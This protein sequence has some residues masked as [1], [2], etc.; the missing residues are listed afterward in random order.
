MGLAHR[1]PVGSE[2]VRSRNAQTDANNAG[3]R[4]KQKVT[5]KGCGG[6]PFRPTTN[7]GCF[8]RGRVGGTRGKRWS[9]AGPQALALPC[10]I[11]PHLLL[12]AL[13]EPSIH[14]GRL[15]SPGGQSVEAQNRPQ[16]LLSLCF[17]SRPTRTHTNKSLRGLRPHSLTPARHPRQP[18]GPRDWWWWTASGRRTCRTSFS[19]RAPMYQCTS[20]PGSH[21]PSLSTRAQR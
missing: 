16:N 12:S 3:L 10:R 8:S 20:V 1:D 17:Q 18:E 2:P 9:R 15:V 6:E 7:V 21:P 11:D 4:A 14:T 19:Q 13:S 5:S